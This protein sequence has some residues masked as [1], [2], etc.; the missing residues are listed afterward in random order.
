MKSFILLFTSEEL[1]EKVLN[2]VIYV[3]LLRKAI[4]T[5]KGEES[6][7]MISFLCWWVLFLSICHQAAAIIRKK[8]ISMIINRLVPHVGLLRKAIP[9]SYKRNLIGFLL[10]T[11][12][13][14]IL[15]NEES[16]REDEL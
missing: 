12:G 5:S 13:F 4:P 9:T 16:G 14:S 1:L 2:K 11:G 15:L 8:L 7:C 3:G 10:F 6:F